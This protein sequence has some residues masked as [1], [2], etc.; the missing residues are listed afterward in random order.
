MSIGSHGW[1]HSPWRG[2]DAD[3]AR[4]ELVDARTRL[5]EASDGAI[6]DAALPLGRYDRRL[7][8]RLR[9]AGYRTV[10][11]SDRHPA[12]SS[13]WLQARYSV[14]AQDS[15]ESIRSILTHRAGAQDARNL[16]AGAV[17]RIR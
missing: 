7:L 6:Q 17:K 16:L 11:T 10:F 3:Q 9:K 14:T 8:S 15:A 1:T 2:L 13:E 4:R 5:A 12:R